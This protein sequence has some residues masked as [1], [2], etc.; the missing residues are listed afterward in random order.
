MENIKQSLND[1]IKTPVENTIKNEPVKKQVQ[2]KQ[3]IQTMF[4]Y[5]L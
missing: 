5:M 3:A 4:I 2:L 1:E